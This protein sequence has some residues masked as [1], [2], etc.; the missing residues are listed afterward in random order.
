[1]L[2][3]VG[4]DGFLFLFSFSIFNMSSHFLLACRVS[5]EK[6]AYC[7]MEVS[8]YIMSCFSLSDFELLIL[9]LT[10]EIWL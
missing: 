5:A 10:F 9:S 6:S 3:I 4:E 7:L 1:M 2:G 8:L